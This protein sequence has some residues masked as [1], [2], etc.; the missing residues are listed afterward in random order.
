MGYPDGKPYGYSPRNERASGRAE[1]NYEHP[2]GLKPNYEHPEGLK[3]NYEPGNLRIGIVWAGN[4]QHEKDAERSTSLK[5][6]LS[7]GKI[8]GVA[9][10]SLQ[11]GAPAEQLTPE[12][13]V[14][15]LGKNLFDFADTAAAI[16]QLDL[17]ISVDTAVAHLAG[18]MGKPVWLL[19]PFTPDWRWLLQRE[20]SPWYP[21]MRLFRQ[22]K[23]GDWQAVFQRVKEQLYGIISALP[24]PSANNSTITNVNK[25][26]IGIGWQLSQVTGWGIY[27]TNLALQLQRHPQFS[28]VLLMPP[29]ISDSQ[30][31][32]L[33]QLL[34]QPVFA[35]Q[36]EIQEIIQKNQGKQIR[37]DFPVIHALG[38]NLANTAVPR[39]KT[40]AGAVFLE[41]TN[42]DADA[43]QRAD[44]YD[45]IIAGSVW[46]EKILIARGISHAVTVQQGI[47]L[48]L[49]H[50]AKK[51]N[52]F[53]DRFVIFA[54][55]KLEYRKGQD[56]V[57]AAF[58]EFRRRHP[59]ALLV[60]AWHNF[61]PQYMRGLEMMGHVTGLPQV[62][63]NG[64]IKIGDWLVAN[65]LPPDSF[66]D[67][68]AVPNLMMPQIIREAD[69]AVFASR[70]EGGTNLAAME[71]MACGIPTIVSANTGHLDLIE[72]DNCYPLVQQQ[73]VKPTPNFAG[74][75]GWG[76]SSVE[77]LIE[78][79]ERVGGNWEEARRRGAAA[80]QFM[81]DWTW[82]KQVGRLLGVL[83]GIL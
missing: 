28:P 66:I 32:P 35:K 3:P 77:E 83:K 34:L 41:D 44:N 74:V 61:W 2:E 56:I 59:Q 26:R 4:P 70:C 55:G 37:C 75:M 47:D 67:L 42:L 43:L 14:E 49:F 58:K 82:E 50:P 65:G 57:I 25:R 62:T 40:N 6:F 63:G 18:A 81:E 16:A 30:L 60:T 46:N 45:I 36:L 8:P 48:S 69:V 1:A 79:W 78:T 10:Y 5:H 21:T 9:L 64:Q 68:G 31:N 38:K 51:S 27:G 22:P 20:D 33:H 80:A 11:K 52:L 71:C 24:N 53:G 15:D 13:P 7:L 17:I 39:G 76:E 73:P 29:A 23:P 54:G 19:L 12:M 72:D